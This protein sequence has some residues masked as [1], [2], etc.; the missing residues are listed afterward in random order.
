M[1]DAL[2]D[3]PRADTCLRAAILAVKTMPGTRWVPVSE[4]LPTREEYLENN[5][6]FLIDD[7]NR[8]YEGHFD[9]F[10]R[11]FK[12]IDFRPE[13]PVIHRDNCA[14]FWRT[15]PEPEKKENR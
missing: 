8:R 9:P 14:A 6:R 10:D 11:E 5:G 13:G 12:V 2:R 3:D 15:F 4:R 7:G 1:R